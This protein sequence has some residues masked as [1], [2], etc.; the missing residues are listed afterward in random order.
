[1][2]HG[3]VIWLGVLMRIGMFAEGQSMNSISA[4]RVLF[5]LYLFSPV[6]L[7]ADDRSTLVAEASTDWKQLEEFYQHVTGKL[8]FSKGSDGNLEREFELSFRLDG[9]NLAFERS[10]NSAAGAKNPLLISKI[11]MG[12]NG[13]YFFS[14]TQKGTEQWISED[15]ITSKET[16]SGARRNMKQDWFHLL[17]APFATGGIPISELVKHQGFR[18]VG[19]STRKA[20]GTDVLVTR[21]EFTPSEQERKNRSL[22]NPLWALRGGTL[23]FLPQRSWAL[24]ST[25]LDVEPIDGTKVVEST[26]IEYVDAPFRTV[27]LVSKVTRS[28]SGRPSIATLTVASL[29]S[30]IVDSKA[31]TLSAFGLPEPVNDL[32]DEHAR[33][34]FSPTVYLVAIVLAL[35]ALGLRTTWKRKNGFVR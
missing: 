13:K 19:T 30:K 35:F 18:I 15:F 7:I 33:S 22:D 27:P 14:V 16:F 23:V 4:L 8:R 1:M 12:I 2:R 11:G 20:S 31:F 21:F 9:D 26:E 25:S 3:A 6:C 29:E 17:N 5:V 10:T 32:D 24:K 34:V 28:Y